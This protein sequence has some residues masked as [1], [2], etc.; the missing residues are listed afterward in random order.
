LKKRHWV[1]LFEQQGYT[2]LIKALKTKA[3][4]VNKSIT[5]SKVTPVS[6]LPQTPDLESLYKELLEAERAEN[7]NKVIEVGEEILDVNS[8][9]KDTCPKTKAAYSYRGFS[10][11]LALEGEKAITDFSRVIQIDPNFILAYYNRAL[12]YK[13]MSNKSAARKDFEMAAELG[14]K[15]AKDELKRL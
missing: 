8:S 1:D 6:I 13:T 12:T 2:R 3:N 5:S 4:Q 10:Y 15:L 7:W 11:F 14:D 9:Y